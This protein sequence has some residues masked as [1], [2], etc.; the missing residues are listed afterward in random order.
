M[1]YGD[2]NPSKK[3]LMGALPDAGQWVRLEVEANKLGLKPGAKVDGMAFTQFGGTVYWDKAGLVTKTPQE[4][5]S[6]VSLLAWEAQEKA[7]EPSPLP[8]DVIE[9]IK[10]AAKRRTPE[11]QK[12]VREYYI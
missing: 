6:G 12:L 5:L 4:D 8:R 1:P 10:I 3:L 2:K 9:A 11:Q 7:K